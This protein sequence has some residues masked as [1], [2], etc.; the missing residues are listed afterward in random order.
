MTGARRKRPWLAALLALLYPGLGH[1]YVRAW[2]RA[3]LW[4]GL[5]MSAVVVLVPDVSAGGGPMAAAEAAWDAT[6]ALPMRTQALLSGMVILEAFDAFVLARRTR[7]AEAEETDPAGT[8]P[9]CGR[10][11]DEDL[12]FCPWCSTRLEE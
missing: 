11:L 6:Q 8:C 4:F 9:N 5:I 10:D 1:L 12:D 2:L 3:L 7:P